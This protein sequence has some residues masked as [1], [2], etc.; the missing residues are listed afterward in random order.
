MV[1]GFGEGGEGCDGSV[2]FDFEGAGVDGVAD[3][4]DGFEE[5]GLLEE[6]FSAGEDDARAVELGDEFRDF[7]G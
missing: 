2:G 6:G 7:G 1:D 4:A 5:F 3:E